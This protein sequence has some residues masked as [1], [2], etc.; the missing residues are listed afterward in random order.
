MPQ[1]H[2]KP[3][4]EP[5][6]EVPERKTDWR[7]VIKD[8]AIL[9]SDTYWEGEIHIPGKEETSEVSFKIK[10]FTGERSKLFHYNALVSM[11]YCYEKV[12]PCVVQIIANKDETVTL[13]IK[14]SDFHTS[15]SLHF[16][17]SDKILTGIVRL[18][19]T[20]D[21][22]PVGDDS[23]TFRLIS[24]EGDNR[25]FAH[26]QDFAESRRLRTAYHNRSFMEKLCSCVW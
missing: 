4:K 1:R 16:K 19:E 14:C 12:E 23:S 24:R 13:Q 8:M 3:R 18:P 20:S 17:G 10:K 2:A 21:D 11:V 9:L 15:G 22:T 25:D 6:K 7:A 26:I 5:R